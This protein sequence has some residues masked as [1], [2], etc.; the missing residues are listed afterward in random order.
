MGFV[1][2]TATRNV[3]DGSHAL[4]KGTMWT[5]LSNL[6]FL[7]APGPASQEAM[8]WGAPG[9]RKG[10]PARFCSPGSGG[11]RGT[12]RLCCTR[13]TRLL[14][15]ETWGQSEHKHRDPELWAGAKGNVESHSPGPL[16][17][18]AHDQNGR[19]LADQVKAHPSTCQF[20]RKAPCDQM[21][22]R[23]PFTYTV[24]N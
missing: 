11:W 22:K 17:T 1:A 6:S 14:S 23:I 16:I 9:R 18:A 10:K 12:P 13:R 7:P 4:V 5:Y 8:Q 21:D 2:P 19:L 3:T 15:S 20:R 24:V